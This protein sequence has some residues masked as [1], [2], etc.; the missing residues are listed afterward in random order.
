MLIAAKFTREAELFKT[1]LS[2]TASGEKVPDDIKA[3]FALILKQAKELVRHPESIKSD[4]LPESI[5]LALDLL[6]FEGLSDNLSPID[7]VENLSGEQATVILKKM[8]YCPVC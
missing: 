4:V 6:K 5:D 1:V 8:E 2:L 3:Y 7:Q